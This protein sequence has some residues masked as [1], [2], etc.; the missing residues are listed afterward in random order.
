MA[1]ERGIRRSAAEELLK[2]M[3]GGGAPPPMMDDEEMM[4]PPDEGGEM[5]PPPSPDEEIPLPEDGMAPPAE[6]D[7]G[8]DMESALAGVESA[9]VGLSEDTAKEIRTHLEAIR[10]IAS[11][12]PGM[13]EAANET[14]IREEMPPPPD[15][16]T[17]PESPDMGM[18]KLPL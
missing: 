15:S 13:A 2:K 9:L 18:E 1:L 5:A 17:P 6:S 3:G 14:D 12:E 11:R 8:M 4:P 7:Q 10:D 16:T